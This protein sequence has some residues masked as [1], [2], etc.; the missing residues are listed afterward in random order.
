M[1]ERKRRL[2]GFACVSAERSNFVFQCLSG[3]L[4]LMPSQISTEALLSS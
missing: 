4:S 2:G 3:K 1:G